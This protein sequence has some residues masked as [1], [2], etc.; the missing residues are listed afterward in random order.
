M[1]VVSDFDRGKKE[2]RTDATLAE[3]TARLDGIEGSLTRFGSAIEA[4]ANAMREGLAKLSAEIGMLQEQGRSAAL[5][6]KVAA[7]TLAADASRRRVELEATAKELAVK[8]SALA[9]T[10]TTNDRSFSKRA[11]ILGL[12][13]TVVTGAA[14]IYFGLHG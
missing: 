14:S 2:G 3:H 10:E 9:A 7:D 12:V 1:S 8:A 4:L 6:V 11:K 5:A 13:F